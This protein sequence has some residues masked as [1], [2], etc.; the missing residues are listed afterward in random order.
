[1]KAPLIEAI[2]PNPYVTKEPTVVVKKWKEYAYFRLGSSRSLTMGNGKIQ[3]LAGQTDGNM[4]LHLNPLKHNQPTNQLTKKVTKDGVQSNHPPTQPTNQPPNQSTT[5]PT[6]QSINQPTNQPT[7]HPTTN[8]PTNHPTN[9]PPTHP[10]NQPPT[11]PNILIKYITHSLCKLL[12][13]NR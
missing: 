12:Q 11:Q 1:L 3:V 7:N 9:Q 4:E 6:N 2:G 5:H 10:T 8:Q 13:Y